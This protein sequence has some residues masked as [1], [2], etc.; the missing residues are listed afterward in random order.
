MFGRKQLLRVVAVLSVAIATG[1][2]VET[3]RARAATAAAENGSMALPYTASLVQVDESNLPVLRGITP[4]AAIRP[5]AD[6]DG[7]APDLSLAVADGAMID[8]ALSAPCNAGERVVLR[9]AGI[10][11]TAQTGADGRLALSLPALQ[12]EALVAVYFEGSAVALAT[13]RVPGAA[14]VSRFAVQIPYPLRV[15]LTGT[16]TSAS[17]AGP[18]ASAVIVGS[19]DVAQPMQ[20]H[21]YT[22]PEV[23]LASA[24]ISAEFRVT[25]QTCGRSFQL[26]TRISQAGGVT[27]GIV[28]VQLPVCGASDGIMVL[29]N[30]VPD[31][32][33]AAPR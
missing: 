23:D 27:A 29:K 20:A 16:R 25:R 18:A 1:Q 10:S 22:F 9:H 33:L 7:C 12:A 4:V 8:V 2:S 30:L 28:P 31:L 24:R 11:L 14:H 21:V 17:A 19:D 13:V 26:E 6:A 3:L 5:G 32:T 15:V